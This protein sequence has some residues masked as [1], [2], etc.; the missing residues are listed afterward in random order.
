MGQWQVKS[1]SATYGLKPISQNEWNAKAAKRS[2]ALVSKAFVHYDA[3]MDFVRNEI[4]GIG[5]IG[6]ESDVPECD[7]LTDLLEHAAVICAEVFEVQP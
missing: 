1:L 2:H 3:P 6:I 7:A 4:D 5:L